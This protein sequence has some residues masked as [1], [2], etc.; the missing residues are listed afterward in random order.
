MV[1]LCPHA[2]RSHSASRKNKN[3][4]ES[5]KATDREMQTQ[6]FKEERKGE[7]EGTKANRRQTCS[8]RY[9]RRRQE[10]GTARDE[11]DGQ[12][13][14]TRRLLKNRLIMHS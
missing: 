2:A 8:K 13:A 3:N 12:Q 7:G 1:V 11:K 9:N 5:E 4:L 14:T 10:N 6:D